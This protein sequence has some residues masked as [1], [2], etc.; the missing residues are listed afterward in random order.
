MTDWA[1][2]VEI[3]QRIWRDHGPAEDERLTDRHV[4]AQDAALAAELDQLGIPHH[5]G[6][7]NRPY[8]DS[9]GWWDIRADRHRWSNEFGKT[10]DVAGVWADSAEEAVIHRAMYPPHDL[11]VVDVTRRTNFSD[12]HVDVHEPAA[13]MWV[14]QTLFD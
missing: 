9:Y 8:G 3:G 6:E 13:P 1:R 11:V 2:L 7:K 14:Q 5:V 4:H 12:V 10:T